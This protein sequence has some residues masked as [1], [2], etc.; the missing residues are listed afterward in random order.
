MLQECSAVFELVIPCDTSF[1]NDQYVELIMS[2]FSESL[3]S[4]TMP[5]AERVE[6]HSAIRTAQTFVYLAYSKL[7]KSGVEQPPITVSIDSINSHSL[8]RFLRTYC[9]QNRIFK[10]R[11]RK[12]V[13]LIS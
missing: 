11:L 6:N 5:P 9:L 2:V 4:L 8:L 1:F 13:F 3:H 12:S 7:N 10:N